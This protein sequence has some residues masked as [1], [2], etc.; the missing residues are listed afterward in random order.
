VEEEHLYRT[1]LLVGST[2]DRRR[3]L[4]SGN[5]LQMS[6]ADERSRNLPS[7]RKLEVLAGLAARDFSFHFA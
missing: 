7:G 4:P 2:D 1:E 6:V 5:L 3:N